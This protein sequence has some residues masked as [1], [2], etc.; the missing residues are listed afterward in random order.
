[1]I[2]EYHWLNLLCKI[3]ER[4]LTSR[5]RFHEGKV[6]NVSV[7]PFFGIEAPSRRGNVRGD[8]A[9]AFS[10]SPGAGKE[11]AETVVAE[12]EALQE[13]GPS[14]EDMETALQVE[15]RSHE[16][17]VQENSWWLEVR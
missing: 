4:R 11:L 5:L 10:C 17:E 13:D 7:S 8:I 9:V 14:R 16:E 3:L 2:R 6:Y 1:M 15:L 12:M